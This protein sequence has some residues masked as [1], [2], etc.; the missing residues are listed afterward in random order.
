MGPGALLTGA[1]GSSKVPNLFKHVLQNY[2]LLFPELPHLKAHI[3]EWVI[4]ISFHI[5]HMMKA[6]SVPMF[7]PRSLLPVRLMQLPLPPLSPKEVRRAVGSSSGGS[8]GQ[9]RLH[10][11]HPCVLVSSSVRWGQ[12]WNLS[13]RC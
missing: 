3:N 4:K 13:H 9:G 5:P 6:T 12:K 2:K 1:E 7:L 8:T 11:S 10:L